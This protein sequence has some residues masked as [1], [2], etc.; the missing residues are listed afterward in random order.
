MALPETWF[1]HMIEHTHTHT[2]TPVEWRGVP[3][4]APGPD[5]VP[6]WILNER[7]GRD[8]LSNEIPNIKQDNTVDREPVWGIK[9]NHLPE[10][11]GVYW[12]QTERVGGYWKRLLSYSGILWLLMMMMIK[13]DKMMSRYTSYQHT[14]KGFPRDPHV[15]QPQ[16]M[17]ESLGCTLTAQDGMW[18]FVQG[19][20]ATYANHCVKEAPSRVLGCQAPGDFLS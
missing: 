6:Y 18:T 8:Q 9:F 7:E 15:I 13:S 1:K 10:Q 4:L 3:G 17:D 12:H 2:N 20:T 19:S 5:G 11:G 16:G 14:H